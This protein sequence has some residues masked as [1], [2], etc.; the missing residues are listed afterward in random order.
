MIVVQ[1]FFFFFSLTG[2][3]KKADRQENWCLAEGD[4]LFLITKSYF[5]RGIISNGNVFFFLCS[6]YYA[7]QI[8]RDVPFA[9]VRGLITFVPPRGA[10][11]PHALWL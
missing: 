9:E 3:E 10:N 1:V 4:T 7:M 6:I 8:A 2:R 5:L 11:P